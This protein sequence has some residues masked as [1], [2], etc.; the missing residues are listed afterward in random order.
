[1]GASLRNAAKPNPCSN[2]LLGQYFERCS[3]DFLAHLRK[4]GQLLQK[5][6]KGR[7]NGKDQRLQVEIENKKQTTGLVIRSSLSD[8]ES[9][10]MANPLRLPP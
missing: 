6:G 9:I 5:T 7:H 1:M 2:A 4:T 8:A 3:V 10:A